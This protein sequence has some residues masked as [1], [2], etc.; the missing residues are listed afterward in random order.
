MTQSIIIA[1]PSPSKFKEYINSIIENVID[2]FRV[3]SSS[4]NFDKT[5]FLQFMT[6]HD[7][8]MD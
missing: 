5:Y 4:L 6:K 7:N 3:N 1:N 2:W 8:E